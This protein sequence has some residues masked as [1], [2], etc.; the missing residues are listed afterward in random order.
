MSEYSEILIDHF[1]NPRNV[2][3]IDRPSAV[4]HVGNPVCGDQLQLYALIEDG[5]VTR[6]SYRAYGCAASLAT[7]SLLTETLRGRHVDDLLTMSED[8]IIKLAG[9][10]S[11]AQR[12]CASM[13]REAI[14]SLV[15]S[16]RGG[17]AIAK[18]AENGC[19]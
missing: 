15:T 17:G 11:P 19:C 12:H 1:S 13:A 7:G 6:C 14:Q 9:G 4:A 16:Y 5:L 8:E 10:L 2:G 18:P 3:E